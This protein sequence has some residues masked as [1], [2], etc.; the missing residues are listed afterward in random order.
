[1]QTFPLEEKRKHLESLN[2][3]AKELFRLKVESKVN[4]D[5]IKDRMYKTKP[6][7]ALSIGLDTEDNSKGHCHLLCFALSD[8]EV[9][10][11]FDKESALLWLIFSDFNAKIAIN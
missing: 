5:Q 3:Q 9:Y 10:E 6:V 1:M 7:E 8:T 2:E 4:K 11:F